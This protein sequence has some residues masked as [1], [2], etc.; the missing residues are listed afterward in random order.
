MGEQNPPLSIEAIAKL[1]A[2]SA[3]QIAMQVA[4]FPLDGR[5]AAFTS[6]AHA[7]KEAAEIYFPK[8]Q[9]EVLVALQ[10]KVIREMVTEIDVGGQPQ[11]GNA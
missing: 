2:D 10:M 11:G 1:V 4:A 5:E 7:I 8:Q 3:Q 9:T 6:V